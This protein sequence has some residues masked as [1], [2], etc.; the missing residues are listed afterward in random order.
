VG[1]TRSTGSS[2]GVFITSGP[3]AKERTFHRDPDE[4]MR[5]LRSVLQDEYC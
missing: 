3:M 1:V 2:R 5:K 4:T